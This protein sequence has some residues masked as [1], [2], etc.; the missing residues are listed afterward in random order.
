M[1]ARKLPPSHEGLEPL[2]FTIRGHRVIL[3]ADLA[4]LYGVTTKVLNQAVK[5]NSS[6]FPEDFAF[7]L[8]RVEVVN[9]SQSA[10]LSSQAVDSELDILNRSQ[11]VT[12]SQRHRDPR[13]HPWAFTEHGALMAANILRS[14]RAV[15][16]SVFVIRAFVRLREQIA[17]NSAI[18][19]RLAEIDKSLLQHDAA[20]R[21]IYRKL[22]PLLQ[23]RPEPP[24]E[25]PKRRIGFISD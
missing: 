10:T 21:D 1:S 20:L 17:A 4:R 12:S 3:D 13:F 7:R 14:A 23:P 16:M 18:L 24:P 19:K 6:R 5:R 2:I 11:I 25:P 8:T 9:W 15:H 22:L